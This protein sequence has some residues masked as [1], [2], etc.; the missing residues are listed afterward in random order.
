M[1]TRSK[2]PLTPEQALARHEARRAYDKA[3]Y[4]TEG[5]RLSRKHA[6]SRAQSLALKNRG[7]GLREAIT[8]LLAIIASAERCWVDASS[9][10]DPEAAKKLSALSLE[11]AAL[12]KRTL[13]DAERLRNDE[14]IRAASAVTPYTGI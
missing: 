7:L 5:P 6:E 11:L 13:L 3:R 10:H 1:A 8:A 2:I 9:A 14:I 4:K 12:A